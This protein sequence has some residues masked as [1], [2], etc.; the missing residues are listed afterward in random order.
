MA[1]AACNTHLPQVSKL[2]ECENSLET[3]PQF[4]LSLF[5]FKALILLLV[6]YKQPLADTASLSSQ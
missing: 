3:G 4:F 6:D 5:F 1:A 2:E